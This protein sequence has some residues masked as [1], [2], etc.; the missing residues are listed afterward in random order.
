MVN[1]MDSIAGI[2]SFAVAGLMVEYAGPATL[3]WSEGLLA[4]GAVVLMAWLLTGCVK[5]TVVAAGGVKKALAS[6]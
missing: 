5:R 1:T 2:V 3:Y 6:R 4:L